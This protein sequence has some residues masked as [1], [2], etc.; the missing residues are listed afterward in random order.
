MTRTLPFNFSQSVARN[1][2]YSVWNIFHNSHFFESI[3]I[4]WWEEIAVRN[5]NFTKF[6]F[7]TLKKTVIRILT[8]NVNFKFQLFHRK[9]A[10]AENTDLAACVHWSLVR[11]YTTSPKML[12]DKDTQSNG[13]WIYTLIWVSPLFVNQGRMHKQWGLISLYIC[14]VWSVIND[15]QIILKKKIWKKCC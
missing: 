10:P 6:I 15:S 5:V 11:N 3:P 13:T 9:F 2:P 14:N 12:F 8:Q 1:G 4:T 7:R